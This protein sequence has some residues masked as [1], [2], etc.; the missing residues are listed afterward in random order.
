MKPTKQY[1]LDKALLLFNE[2]GFVNV[3]LQHI[4]DSAFVSIGHLAYHFKNKDDIILSLY[5]RLKKKQE[6]L[7]TEFRVL[8]LFEDIDFLLRHVYQLQ[9]Q[10]RFFY[11]DTLEVIR[12]LPDIAEKH[13]QLLSFQRQQIQFMMEF[14]AS[15]GSFM[16]PLHKEQFAQLAHI[17]CMTMDNWMSY[18]YING[19]NEA[20]ETAYCK[21][22]W[23]ILRVLFTDMGDP[24]F[25]QLNNKGI[26]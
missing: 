23:S 20:D 5:K 4:A 14:N 7:L 26:N 22:L 10:Y 13:R 8:P 18:Q 3:R 11:L 2:K 21:D 25:R 1:I 17:F 15:R 12:A 24:E 9:Q 16:Q 19:N 6:L